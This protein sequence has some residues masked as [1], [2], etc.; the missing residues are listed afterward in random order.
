MAL[1]EELDP[2]HPEGIVCG[3]RRK[4]ALHEQPLPPPLSGPRGFPRSCP[5][6]GV[7][8]LG[9]RA[10]L[11]GQRLGSSSRLARLPRA[12]LSGQLLCSQKGNW[13]L[14]KG[15]EALRKRCFFLIESL[16]LS[17]EAGW[18]GSRWFSVPSLRFP[19]GDALA[20]GLRSWGAWCPEGEGWPP[21]DT[22]GAR[23]DTEPACPA[24]ASWPGRSKLSGP[25]TCHPSTSSPAG[26]CV[27]RLLPTGRVL[28]QRS[29][30][31]SGLAEMSIGVFYVFIQFYISVDF[32]KPVKLNFLNG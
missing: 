31:H 18:G 20:R 4:P 16:H 30:Q 21:A 23:G 6:R 12:F 15:E 29:G 5:G 22:Q 3:K 26:P 19:L 28:S 17:V 32:C 13:L 2:G 10:S 7:G 25:L 14:G 8:Q 9:H 1:P 11:P 24:S 27:R